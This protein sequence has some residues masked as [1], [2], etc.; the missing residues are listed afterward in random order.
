M[1]EQPAV[2]RKDVS[3]TL[4]S[5]AE[6]VESKMKLVKN[7]KVKSEIGNPRLNDIVGQAKSDIKLV[8]TLNGKDSDYESG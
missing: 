6:K 2:N 7:E 1:A 3:S 5:P 8:S 4:T